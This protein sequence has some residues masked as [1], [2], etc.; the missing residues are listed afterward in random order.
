MEKYYEL[1]ILSNTHNLNTDNAITIDKP[2]KLI[3]DVTLEIDDITYSFNYLIFTNTSQISNFYETNILHENG[4]PV[5][6]FYY[7]TTY[8]NI[9]YQGDGNI[10]LA[11]ETLYESNS[12][13]F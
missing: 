11:I 9:F 2:V 4:I 10:E 6:N 8:E 13:L 7:Q 12:N 1:I 5:T 3:N